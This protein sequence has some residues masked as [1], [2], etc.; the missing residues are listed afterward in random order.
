MELIVISDTKIKLILT[1]SDMKTYALDFETADYDSPKNRRAIWRLFDDVKSRSGFDI[2][3]ERVLV[4]VWPSRD[5]GCEMFISK[6]STPVL[7]GKTGEGG[8]RYITYIYV[9]EGLKNLLCVC[10]ALVHRAYIKPSQVWHDEG[11]WYLFLEGEGGKT[12]LHQFSF[13]EEFATKVN[14]KF[15]P[16][17]FEHAVPI[18][19]QGAVEMLTSFI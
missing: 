8:A 12:G 4:Q 3:F 2:D 9:F 18:A 5:G 15:A 16:I 19:T 13:I 1:A 6:I 7:K 11:K 17:I 10:K 14:E